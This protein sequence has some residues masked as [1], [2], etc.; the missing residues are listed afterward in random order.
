MRLE[1]TDPLYGGY[2][3]SRG[4]GVVF[5]RGALPGEV[6][7][8]EI[9]EKKRDYSVANVVEVLEP[10]PD[11]V[12]PPC[13]VFGLCGGC[14]YQY[15][16]PNVQLR[17]KEAITSDTLRRIGKTEVM[18]DSSVPSEPWH[19]RRRVQLKVSRDGR[20]GFYRPLSH[21]VV[22]FDECLL[23]IDELN[24]VIRE[25]KSHRLPKGVKEVF[26]QAGN[27]VYTAFREDGRS[28]KETVY[29]FSSPD[30]GVISAEE[31]GENRQISLDMDGYKY[32]ISPGVFFQSNW[33]LNKRLLSVLRG[34]VLSISP[35]TVVDLY[36]GA[37]NFSIPIAADVREV[38]AIE[39]NLS[40]FN[41]GKDNLNVNG[42][43]NVRF[44]NRRVESYSIRSPVDLLIIDPPRQGLLKETV[45]GITEGLPQWIVYISCNPSTFA[46]DILRLKNHY[47]VESLRVVD[48]FPQT[49]HIEVFGILK[50]V[51]EAAG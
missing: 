51:G 18:L 10:S 37:G 3:L 35:E 4:D 6:V 40:A 17:M 8:A 26:L 19:Y 48:M 31:P 45:K 20:V 7:E 15:I 22:E 38:I 5:L 13:P 23:L 42:I 49:Y 1:A 44:I 36:A 33:E 27:T 11:R 50:R 16:A 43:R 46:R 41:D 29:R 9:V 47:A 2:T 12:I 21:D 39:E 32:L 14:H 24:R 30:G 25:I 34:F 28:I